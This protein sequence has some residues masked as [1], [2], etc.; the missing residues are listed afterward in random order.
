MRE[1]RA[2]PKYVEKYNQRD[3]I[4]FSGTRSI[5]KTRSYFLL[6]VHVPQ[7]DKKFIELSKREVSTSFENCKE[8]I[9]A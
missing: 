6:F 3:P 7:L 1:L 8:K 5:L 9:E 2:Q 4:P